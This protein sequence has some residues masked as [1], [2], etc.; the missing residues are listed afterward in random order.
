MTVNHLVPGSIPGAGATSTQ[1]L[2]IS[3]L[4]DFYNKFNPLFTTFLQQTNQQ[5][6]LLNEDTK[7][8]QLI[9]KTYYFV[10]RFKDK[11]FKRTLRTTNL[12]TAN[13]PIQTITAIFSHKLCCHL[14]CKSFHKH[15]KWSFVI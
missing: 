10:K 11:I 3:Q 15:L 1:T 12:K 13:T 9:G 6:Q 8:L 5:E 2:Y 4:E 7:Y 14:A